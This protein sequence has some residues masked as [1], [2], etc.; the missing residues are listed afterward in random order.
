MKARNEELVQQISGQEEQLAKAKDAIEFSFER[1]SA[2]L[3]GIAEIHA[4]GVHGHGGR[5]GAIARK[6][7]E[8]AGLSAKEV[9]EVAQAALLH[10][11]G[12]VAVPSQLLRIPE[13]TLNLQERKVLYRHPH[14]GYELLKD[15]EG[16]EIVAGLVRGHHEALDGSGYPDGLFADDISTASRIITIADLYDSILF[17]RNHLAV[18]SQVETLAALK[19]VAGKRIDADLVQLLVDNIQD[20]PDVSCPET[21]SLLVTQLLPEMILAEAIKDTKG[22]V[23]Y[24]PET[25]LDR[26]IITRLQG[27]RAMDSV[28]TRIEVLSQSLEAHDSS[29]VQNGPTANSGRPLVFAVDDEP[30]VL[31]ALRRELRRAG[32][33]V[34]CFNAPQDLLDALRQVPKGLIAVLCDFNMPG[35]KGDV[36]I[37]RIHR[38]NPKLPCIVISGET[39]RGNLKRLIEVGSVHSILRK[40][41]SK[42][43]LLELLAAL[44]KRPKV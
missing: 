31:Q 37:K 10:D 32:Y 22:Q 23:L 41:W 9:E 19:Q 27:S 16:M 15:V 12:L 20:I 5:T 40:P 34:N 24:P 42:E 21:V 18:S 38:E 25:R 11:V 44:R 26:S 14:I 29:H 8:L 2:L 33:D 28:S 13:N 39:T 43:K 3:G 30:H 4:P 35:I 6:L 17:P 1:F 36:L 7:A